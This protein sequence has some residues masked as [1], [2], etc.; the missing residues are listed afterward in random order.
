MLVCTH[1]PTHIHKYICW[2]AA[3]KC[4]IRPPEHFMR[5]RGLILCNMHDEFHEYVEEEKKKAYGNHCAGFMS[6]LTRGAAC[7]FMWNDCKFKAWHK[8]KL[9]STRRQTQRQ[10]T[11]EY[12]QWARSWRRD[13]PIMKHDSPWTWHYWETPTCAVLWHGRA[14]WTN[15]VCVCVLTCVCVY[16]CVHVRA[17]LDLCFPVKECA[18]ACE[19]ACVY[20]QECFSCQSKGQLV[21]WSAA[22]PVVVTAADCHEDRCRKRGE[23]VQEEGCGAPQW[24]Q[25]G[26][27]HN[28]EHKNLPWNTALSIP[29]R[30]IQKCPWHQDMNEY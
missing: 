7:R 20:Q 29:Q 22:S 4:G 13:E 10:T 15:T 30:T 21:I 6:E 27:K 26:E 11:T 28:G 2:N 23:R 25:Y 19:R 14:K 24:S 3:K 16:V 18:P 1:L 9:E 17:C 8:M 12:D 5:L